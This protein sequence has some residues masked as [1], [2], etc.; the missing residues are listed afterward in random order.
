MTLESTLK[1]HGYYC[2]SRRSGPSIRTRSCVFCARGKVSCDNKRPKC[3]R[4]INKGIDCHYP[5]NTRGTKDPGQGTHPGRSRLA[6]SQAESSPS[7]PP[8]GNGTGNVVIDST[9]VL[10]VL[11]LPSLEGGF[12]WDD[13]GI[14][15]A[16]ILDTQKCNSS[17]SLETSTLTFQPTTFAA[18]TYLTPGSLDFSSPPIPTTPTI[19]VRSLIHRP[20]AQ[21][22]TQRTA[23]LI[24]HNLKSYPLMIQCHN[25]LPPFIHSSLVSA[26]DEDAHMEPLTN[27][28]SLVLMLNGGAQASRKLFWKNVR[29]EFERLSV[30]VWPFCHFSGCV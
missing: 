14:G 19:A 30:E 26:S 29:M 16:D 10:P 1:R 6:T 17:L 8:A 27:C 7:V 25:G 13:G 28:L 18:Q 9:P 11:E 12:D 20:N 4:C 5:V 22:G 21:L 2:R 23:K 15:L 3:S 24:L